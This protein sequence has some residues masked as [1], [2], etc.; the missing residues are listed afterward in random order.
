MQ[1]L[2][3]GGGLSGLA[4]A[5]ALEACGEDYM[6]VEARDRVGGRIFTE[7]HQSGYFDLGPAWFWP[8]QPRMAELVARLGL[9]K[10]DQH[11]TGAL[12]FEDAHG[13]V[14]HG[15][16]FASMEGSSRLV[17]GLQA[18]TK[19]L[20]DRLPTSRLRLNAQVTSLSQTEKAITVTLSDG[21]KVTASQVVLAM[22][23]RIAAK[24][25]FSP[26]LPANAVQAMRDVRTWMAGQAKALAVYDRPFWREAGLSGDATSRF[27][28]MVEI[29]DASPASGGPYG[30]FGFIGLPPH[31][32]VDEQALR[33]DLIAQIVRLFGP[34]GAQPTKL[35]LKDWAFDPNTSTQ[36]DLEP[37]YSHPDYGM[38][39]SLEGL[40]DNK[41]LFAG[42]EVASEFGGYLEGALGAAANVLTTLRNQR[43]ARDHAR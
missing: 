16:G 43:L 11:S 30:L 6:L 28:P 19:A 7:F 29:H 5:E 18:L 23:P 38:P 12:T 1:T 8:G 42:T 32:R 33:H 20:A 9:E 14:Q 24:L 17:G 40:W 25:S 39:E 3:I 15:R 13:Q 37:L 41:L 26:S 35:Y 2:I 10:F 31:G 27:G 34:D 4:L 36:A 22:P 21:A